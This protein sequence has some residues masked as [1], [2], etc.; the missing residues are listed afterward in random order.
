L[1]ASPWQ[2]ENQWQK[3]KRKRF[4]DNLKASIK[5]LDVDPGRFEEIA[6]DRSGWRNAVKCGARWQK[7]TDYLELYTNA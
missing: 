3:K 7:M 4:N 2:K 6:A 1:L 5:A